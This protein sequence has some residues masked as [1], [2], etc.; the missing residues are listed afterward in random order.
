[1]M[2]DASMLFD[3][4]CDSV[5]QRLKDLQWKALEKLVNGEDVFVIQPTGSEK[6]LTYQS[7]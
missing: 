7:V 2:A 5:L 3:S 6:S 1:M 4:A